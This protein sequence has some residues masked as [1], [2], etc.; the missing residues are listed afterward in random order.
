[1]VVVEAV[2]LQEASPAPGP[3]EL[4]LPVFDNQRLS[5]VLRFHAAL[6]R[7]NFGEAVCLSMI[8]NL[9]DSQQPAKQTGPLQQR[10]SE[11]KRAVC[12]DRNNT[13]AT[14]IRLSCFDSGQRTC[15]FCGFCRTV[16][17]KISSPA[18]ENPIQEEDHKFCQKLRQ[19]CDGAQTGP[20][21]TPDDD[22]VQLVS[23][24]F[25]SLGSMLSRSGSNRPG[26]VDFI[27][28]SPAGNF[29]KRRI[30]PW[31]ARTC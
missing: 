8:S 12:C 25:A 11:R 3:L 18:P 23:I 13:I 21:H 27:V 10:A 20:L 22:H 24:R 6:S 16:A 14:V 5:P 29:L 2:A 31:Q 19:V 17:K 30:V 15:S 1:M 9:P 7:R 4:V 28:D 26:S